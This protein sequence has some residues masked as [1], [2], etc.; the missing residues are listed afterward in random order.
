MNLS[1]ERVHDFIE[2]HEISDE[3]QILTIACFIRV[4][5][6]AG[7]NVAELVDVSQVDHSRSWIKRKSP[8]QGSVGLLL[9]SQ[10]AHEVLVVERC[11]DEGMILK[12]SFL[13]Y[14]I[15]PGLAGKV[16]NVELA[17]ADRLYI[18]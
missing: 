8:A 14:P 7:H 13:N 2:A 16:G 12:P 5:E 9:W 11:D 15:N 18:G 4:G 3:W 10:C 6:C 1:I 17:I